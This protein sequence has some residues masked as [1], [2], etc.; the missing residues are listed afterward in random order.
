METRRPC[1]LRSRL[2][3]A[4]RLLISFINLTEVDI[5]SS[6]NSISVPIP[7]PSVLLRHVVE[8]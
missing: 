2:P 3:A 1:Y 7:I 8:N 5:E 4:F 6:K